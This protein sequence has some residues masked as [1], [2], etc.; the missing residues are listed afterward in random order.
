MNWT[1]VKYLKC[2]NFIFGGVNDRFFEVLKHL[3][4]NNQTV[5]LLNF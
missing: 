3:L 5:P 2:Q 4:P 1:R